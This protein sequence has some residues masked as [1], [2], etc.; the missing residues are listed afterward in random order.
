MDF[1]ISDRAKLNREESET[2]KRVE[3][4]CET[5]DNRHLKGKIDFDKIK[6]TI[7][8]IDLKENN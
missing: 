2:H 1:Y 5:T 4:S 6:E 3:I 7:N 8:E